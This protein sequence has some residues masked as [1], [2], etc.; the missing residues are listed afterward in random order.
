MP[1]SLTVSGGPEMRYVAALLRK[2]GLGDLK[3][4]RNKAQR[5]AVKPLQR[6]IRLEA[7][8]TLPGEYAGIMA[9]AVRVSVTHG[10]GDVVLH[11]RVH[12]RGRKEARDVRAVN[13]GRLRHP[14]FG[15]RRRWYAQAVRPGFVTRPVERTWDRVYEASDEAHR[16]YLERIARA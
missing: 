6:E 14:L 7:A 8:A 12:A 1:V 3:K 5:D 4:E 2:A 13:D 11:A 10:R 15:N 16:R 9:R